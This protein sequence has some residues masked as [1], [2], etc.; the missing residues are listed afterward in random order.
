[1]TNGAAGTAPTLHAGQH[2]ATFEY[3]LCLK[4]HSGY[5]RCRRRIAAHPSR[6]ALD[7]G[8]ELNPANVSYHPV[9]AAGNEPDR[10]RWR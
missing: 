8:V 5:T 3:Q 1:M 4:C 7:K 2:V 9:E 6:W 10:T